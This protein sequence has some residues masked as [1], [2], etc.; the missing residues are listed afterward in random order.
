[1]S[2]KPTLNL[3]WL[4][5]IKLNGIEGLV[6]HEQKSIFKKLTDPNHEV[7]WSVFTTLP[8][9]T[10][11]SLQ[12][13]TQRY[14]IYLDELEKVRLEQLMLVEQYKQFDQS[15]EIQLETTLDWLNNYSTGQGR[16]PLRE[17]GRFL[18]PPHILLEDGDDLL[19][20]D[21]GLILLEADSA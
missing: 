3:P 18:K 5:F 4:E 20:E 11:L 15:Q 19:L 1:M 12:E 16:G 8:H 2:H 21:T 6:E 10:Q 7:P 17:M 13:Q 14:K 9:I